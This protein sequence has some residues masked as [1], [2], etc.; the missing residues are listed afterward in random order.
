[1]VIKITSKVLIIMKLVS[2]LLATGTAAGAAAAGAAAAAAGAAAA[3]AVASGTGVT[4]GAATA[5]VVAASVLAGAS[6]K[7][8]VAT[9]NAHRQAIPAS[10]FVIFLRIDIPLRALRCRFHRYGYG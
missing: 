1:M 5:E 6:A 4:A 10:N 7:L 3:G 2:P 9:P 8:G